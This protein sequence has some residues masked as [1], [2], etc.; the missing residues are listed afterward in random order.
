[1]PPPAEVTSLKG[2]VE[3][4]GDGQL[5]LRIP[6]AVGGD[7][8]TPFARSIGRTDG[9]FLVVTIEPWLAEKIHIEA[10]SIVIV[11]NAEG[12]FTITRSADNDET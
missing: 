7:K 6:L 2:R 5:G 11:D 10:G 9:D 12:R 4:L 3:V 8:L 1:L